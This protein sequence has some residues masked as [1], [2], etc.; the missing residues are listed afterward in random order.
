M[1]L[2]LKIR[3]PSD[4][5]YESH[6]LF[7]GLYVTT[8]CCSFLEF[9]ANDYKIHN[10]HVYNPFCLLVANHTVV[11]TTYLECWWCLIVIYRREVNLGTHVIFFIDPLEPPR[12]HIRYFNKWQPSSNKWYFGLD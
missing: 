10:H 3:S 11:D 5:C 6:K 9:L 7:V 1:L 2:E 12:P 8:D 4:T